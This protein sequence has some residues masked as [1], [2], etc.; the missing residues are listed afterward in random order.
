[1]T[2]KQH[3]EVFTKY[4]VPRFLNKNF[5]AYQMSEKGNDFFEF[6]VKVAQ[7]PNYEAATYQ[8]MLFEDILKI[9]QENGESRHDVVIFYI[10]LLMPYVD[11]SFEEDKENVDI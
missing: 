3:W 11:I 5:G 4:K 7:D 10:K 9:V 8:E 2:F 6:C 1:M